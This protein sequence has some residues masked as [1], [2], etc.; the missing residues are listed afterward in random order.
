MGVPKLFAYLLKQ[1]KKTNMVFQKEKMGLEPIEWFLIDTNCCIH[2]TCFKVLAEEQKKENINFKSLQNKMFNAVIA[3]I[4]KLCNYAN[5]TKGIF[6]AIDGPVCAAK[7]KQQRQRRFR[8]VHD[9]QVFDN[10]KKKYNIPI[11][12]YWNNSAISPGTKFM[13]KLHNN[14]IEW[15]NKYKI[16][17]PHLEIIYSSSNVPGEGEHKLLD[18]IKQNI[19]NNYSYLTYGLDADLIFL[20]LVTQSEKVYLLRE[21][22]E[23]EKKSSPDQLNIVS[24]K[25]LRDCILTSFKN[26]LDNDI[27][28]LDKNRIIIDFIFLCYFLGNDFLPHILMLDISHDGIDYMIEKY[29]ETYSEQLEYLISYDKLTINYNFLVRF[30]DLISRNEKTVLIENFNYIKKPHYN[31]SHSKNPEYDKEMFKLDNLL[32]KINDPIGIGVN[33]DYR[34]NYYKHYFG[35]SD[36]ELEDFVEKLVTHYLIGIKWCAYY[37]FHKIPDWNWYYS[38]DYPPFLSDINKYLYDINNVQFIEGKPITPFEQLLNILPPQ[39]SYL[40]PKEISKL[41]TNTK[42]SLA[43]LY[44]SDINIDFLYKKKYWEGITQLPPFEIKLIS[45]VYSKYK[46]EI[47]KNIL[48]RNRLDTNMVF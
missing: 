38:Y 28:E 43:H 15:I 25:I 12:Y 33:D 32:F 7:M 45:H 42:S 27:I 35:V 31:N 20:M 47:N 2:P 41:M 8:S 13:D 26:K 37:Y 34:N 36:D 3:Y 29:T 23:F 40:I 17:N 4:E 22:Q 39:S 6:I 16:D 46:N 5:P 9:K 14:I 48:H 19:E 30:I 18:F 11:P 24:I 21:A 10:I 44:P 1:Y